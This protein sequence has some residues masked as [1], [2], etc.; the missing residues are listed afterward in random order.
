M[1]QDKTHLIYLASPYS[2]KDPYIQIQRFERA[3]AWTASLL[4]RGRIIFSPIAHSHPLVRYGLP[5]RFDF[6]KHFDTTILSRCDE[7]WVL[8]LPGWQDSTGVQSE[9]NIAREHGLKIL[10]L[11]DD[12]DYKRHLARKPHKGDRS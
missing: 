10:Y 9:I 2:H 4:R 3:C 5:E 1:T 7:L 12:P 11:R 6:W 8:Q